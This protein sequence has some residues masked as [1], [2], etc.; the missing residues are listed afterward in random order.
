MHHLHY[1]SL[2]CIVRLMACRQKHLARRIKINSI[3]TCLPSNEP[4][5][6]PFG[7]Q[8]WLVGDDGRYDLLDHSKHFT[9]N[10]SNPYNTPVR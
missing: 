9:H 5:A 6:L 7:T 8:L 1:V 2:A 10:L 3:Q 4:I